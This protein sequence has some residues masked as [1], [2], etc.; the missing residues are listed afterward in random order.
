LSKEYGGRLILVVLAAT[1]MIPLYV[2]IIVGIRYGSAPWPAK[3]FLLAPAVYFTIVH[4]VSVGSLRYRIPA[5]VPM[6]VLAGLAVGILSLPR[7]EPAPGPEASTA[8]P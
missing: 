5:D 3:S 2:L 1:Y 6:A 7:Q 4:A 8:N